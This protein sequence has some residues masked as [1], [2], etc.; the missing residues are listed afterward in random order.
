MQQ[1]ATWNSSAAAGLPALLEAF[2]CADVVAPV[3]VAA[4]G[5]RAGDLIR[6]G[7]RAQR[8]RHEEE[9]STAGLLLTVLQNAPPSDR[10][11]M[12]AAVSASAL[13]LVTAG[14]LVLLG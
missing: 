8:I 10:H 2:G 4:F 12:V 1:I 14:A 6:Q 9:E 5:K 3:D 13:L 7:A 11:S